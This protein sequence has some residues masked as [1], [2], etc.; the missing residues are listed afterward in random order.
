MEL[1]N[2]KPDDQVLQNLCVPKCV[3][4][5]VDI[6]IGTLYNLI[7]PKPIHHLANGLTIYSCVL[8]SHDSSINATIGG[9]HSSFNLMA[10][11]FGGA[12]SL[13]VHFVNGLE[14]FQQWGPP[15]IPD[16]P[17]T[18]EENNLAKL[19]NCSEG[20]PIYQD[21]ADVEEIED[22]L[23]E[24][25]ESNVNTQDA[26]ELEQLIATSGEITSFVVCE[27][28]KLCTSLNFNKNSTLA[29]FTD[30]E[31]ISPLSRL[32]L[33]EDG[34]LN[35]EYR[36]VKCRDCSDC[37]NAAETDKISLREEAEMHMIR[38]S[39]KL[40]LP[41]KRIICSLPLRGSEKDFLTTNR[42]RALQVLDQQCRKYHKDKEV[43]DIAIKAFKK[44]FDNG[45]AALLDDLDDDVKK[46]FLEKDPQ[47]FIPWRLVFKPDSLSTPCRAVLD[48]SSR[49]KFRPD[50]TAGRC[51]NDVVVKG[52][53]TTIN[54]VKLVLRFR[55]GLFGVTCDL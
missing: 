26:V 16:N 45:H 54:L 17:F 15:S 8:A 53:I 6:L 22:Y 50:G 20:D 31:K 28:K 44:L 48:G 9:P 33:L 1:K 19:L 12:A 13:M 34:G 55:A 7:F 30:L 14:R 42:D 47:Y 52:K 36:C 46:L 5:E 41:N 4:G 43:K 32:R 11:S 51:L 49:T 39:V 25:I 40:D 23:E 29:M 18:V 10:D 27:C 21:L 3:G 37:R 35:I 24:R 38:E 2:D